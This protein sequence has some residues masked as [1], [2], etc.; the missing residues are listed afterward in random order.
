MPQGFEIC[1]LPRKLS[2]QIMTWLRRLPP[3]SQS[4]KVPTRSGI[5]TS[6]TIPH[7]SS[8]LNSNTTLSLTPSTLSAAPASSAPLPMPTGSED[9]PLLQE[10]IQEHRE[11][12]A[13]PS[14]L[15]LRPTGQTGVAALATMPQGSSPNFYLIS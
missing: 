10:L 7:S 1:P 3:T 2:L 5:D 11:L 15:W 14:T 6:I 4:P 8:G 12:V 9:F 13:T